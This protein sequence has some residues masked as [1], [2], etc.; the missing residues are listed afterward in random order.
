MTSSAV[1]VGSAPE[2]ILRWSG[3][4]HVGP[5]RLD[6]LTM[7]APAIDSR[8]AGPRYGNKTV[9]IVSRQRRLAL[10]SRLALIRWF[11]NAVDF[12]PA[13]EAR[14]SPPRGRD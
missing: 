13:E 5:G 9:N 1:S 3:H 12:F 6:Q 11:F 8:H 10:F 4:L 2:P 7:Q 14:Y